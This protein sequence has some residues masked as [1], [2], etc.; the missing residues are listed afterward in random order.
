MLINYVIIH[1]NKIDK[2]FN[3]TFYSWPLSIR[4]LSSQTKDK[5]CT[6]CGG[7]TREVTST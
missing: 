4:D 7:I 3:L 2:D 5:T 1:K 6:P